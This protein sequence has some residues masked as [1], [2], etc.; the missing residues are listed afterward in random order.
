MRLQK[1]FTVKKEE[2]EKTKA[3]IAAIEAFGWKVKEVKEG[4]RHLKLTCVI[5]EKYLKNKDVDRLYHRYMQNR[6]PI[7][8]FSIV[9]YFLFFVSLALFIVGIFYR[10]ELWGVIFL[11][12]FGIIAFMT[13][14]FSLSSFFLIKER[15]QVAK[16]SVE[17]AY[18]LTHGKAKF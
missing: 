18:I 2:K 14:F 8:T 7:S 15:K 12:I 5:E 1:Q 16:E 9:S 13:F 4:A 10:L 11:L 6:H 17:E 3:N